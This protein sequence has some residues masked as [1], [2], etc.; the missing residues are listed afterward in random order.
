MIK[1][2][3]QRWYRSLGVGLP[4]ITAIVLFGIGVD[5]KENLFSTGI[6]PSII[7]GIGNLFIAWSVWKNKI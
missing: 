4:L 3:N 5:V 7:L 2:L 6:T 1:I